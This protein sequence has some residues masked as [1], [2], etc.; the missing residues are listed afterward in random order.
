[1]ITN[2]LSP[3]EFRVSILRLPNVSFF[4]QRT[5]LPS[6]STSP[7]ETPTPFNKIYQTPDKLTYSNL[8]L[9]FIVDEHMENYLEIYNWI[10]DISFPRDFRE[11]KQIKESE[12]GTTSDITL[13]ILNSHKNG[14]I[15][16][17]YINCFPI[18]LSEITMDTTQQDVVYPEVTATFQYDSFSIRKI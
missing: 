14:N 4:V 3:L 9:T 2:Y 10:N 17:T 13:H 1:M 6:V 7:V 12:A 5:S 8:D 15:E 11:Y 18:S 16:V